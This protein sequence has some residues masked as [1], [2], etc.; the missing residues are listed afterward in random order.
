MKKVIA[1]LLSVMLIF[2]TIVF[3][4]TTALADEEGCVITFGSVPAH[5][6]DTVTV[7]VY[8]TNNPGIAGINMTIDLQE[9]LT[10]NLERGAENGSLF[11]GFKAGYSVA[12]DSASNVTSNGLLMNL[13]ITVDDAAA[14]GTYTVSGA[15]LSCFNERFT[16]VDYTIVPGTITVT[17]DR[18]FPTSITLDKTEVSIK[19]GDSTDLTAS[20]L[21]LDTT[22]T[23][24]VWKTSNYNVATV[25]N[26][27][28]T[29]V[30]MGSAVIIVK[31]RFVARPEVGP[32]TGQGQTGLP[33]IPFNYEVTASCLVTVT[34]GHES[35]TVVRENE[36]TPTSEQDG[37]YDEV[38]YCDL[39][40]EVASSRHIVLPATGVHQNFGNITTDGFIA[41]NT[42]L[43]LSDFNLKAP[44][45]VVESVAVDDTL[46][47]DTYV[48]PPKIGSG[49]LANYYLFTAE[50]AAHN[51]VKDISITLY[52]NEDIVTEFGDDG[53][54]T[55]TVKDMTEQY[56][57]Y[58][59]EG[60]AGASDPKADQIVE[61]CKTYL[62][63]GSRAQQYFLIDLDN[64]ADENYSIADRVEA[65]SPED[66]HET[67]VMSVS[68]ATGFKIT[69]ASF[70]VTSKSSIRYYYELTDTEISDYTFSATL[71]GQ[72]ASVRT[73]VNYSNEK[74]YVEIYNIAA[75][76]LDAATV[77]TITK[78]SDGTTTTV[79][80]NAMCYA[81]GIMER[82]LNEESI[83]LCKAMYLY[84]QAANAFFDD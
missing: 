5:Q 27:I 2:S 16:N 72:A 59:G 20:F 43:D 3:N 21:P 56:I 41:V 52:D 46:Q 51:M 83:A 8:L 63:Y 38:S 55:T 62:A 7:P 84:N 60:G 12:L 50:I 37:G 73:N 40:G 80:Y 44:K 19:V 25:S 35:V 30:S 39:C 34:C 57:E 76:D 45:V 69:K 77:L 68:R 29:G 31:A 54:Y 78:K 42:Y 70:M 66:I 14:F 10:C 58:Y 11:T 32:P 75:K 15:V 6:G 48:K 36:L 13:R 67:R 74:P 81:K 49:P 65:V 79:S 64:L 28:V 23:A 47:T 82:S 1:V 18:V 4:T 71:D 24:V 9:K 22:E 61:L 26:G 33:Y 53:V 17:D